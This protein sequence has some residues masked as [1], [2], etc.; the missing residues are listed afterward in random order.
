[1]S[2]YVDRQGNPVSLEEWDRLIEDKRIAETT[3]PDGKWISTVWLG[4]NHGSRD[5]P[6]YFETMVFPE[7]DDFSGLDCERYEAEAEA[8]YGHEAMVAKWS[9]L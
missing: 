1:M 5:A 8:K 6:L 9:K 7:K 3:L 4:I 2:R